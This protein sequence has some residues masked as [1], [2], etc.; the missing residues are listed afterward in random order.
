MFVVPSDT[1]H[2]IA[3]DEHGE[4]LWKK[5]LGI[6]PSAALYCFTLIDMDQDG[7][8]EIYIVNNSDPFILSG[9]KLM[10]WNAWT[11]LQEM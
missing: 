4:V 2:G 3:F 9:W 10:C 8:D 5:E 11:C 6:W 7:I 1:L